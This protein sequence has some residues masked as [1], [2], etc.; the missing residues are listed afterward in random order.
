MT[1]D[2]LKG[3]AEIP[4]ASPTSSSNSR[5]APNGSSTTR[6]STW[7][8]SRPSSRSPACPRARG[9]ARSSSTRWRWRAKRF[10]A[11]ATTS[12]RC[13]SASRVDNAQR[14]L[15]G[16]L[17]DAELLAEVYLAMT[18][19]QESLTI[20]IAV[21]ARRAGHARAARRRASHRR[22][23]ARPRDRAERRGARAARRIPGRARPR[24]ERPLR[25]ARAAG[26]RVRDVA[27][28]RRSLSPARRRNI[29]VICDGQSDGRPA[30]PGAAPAPRPRGGGNR[31]SH[32][33]VR[34]RR[35][36]A[37]SRALAARV[38]PPR[39]GAR[40]GC[41]GAAAR[42]AA[43]PLHPRQQS[44]RVLRDPRRGH[45][46]AAARQGVAPRA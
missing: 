4:G 32:A 17:L 19:G 6:R 24:I 36:A 14:T 45:Q 39:A 13:A 28:L 37:Q 30:R 38:Q 26:C 22:A 42:A 33:H 7:R 8:S 21:P 5:A 46:G 1:W 40:R 2:D 16:A 12:T 20:D 43:L 11:S 31:P 23:A 18:R 27:R 3:Q 41:A 44:R 29:A 25:L 10:P 9:S 35:A 15:H 34:R